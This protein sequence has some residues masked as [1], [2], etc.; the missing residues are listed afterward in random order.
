M[1]S[2]L[3]SSSLHSY[4]SMFSSRVVRGNKCCSE[5]ITLSFCHCSMFTLSLFHIGH[6]RQQFLQTSCLTTGCSC[7]GIHGLCVL[8]ASSTA[9]PWPSPSLPVEICSMWCLWSAGRQP[10]PLWVFLGL[11]GTSALCLEHLLP[12]FHRAVS[13]TLFQSSLQAAVV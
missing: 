8:Q 9:V 6:C 12:S 1:K 11:Q 5:S 13:L 2:K 7:R 10:A 4:S 3:N